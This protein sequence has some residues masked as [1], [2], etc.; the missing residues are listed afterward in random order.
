MRCPFCGHE[1]TS[2]KDSRSADDNSAIRRRRVCLE[3][4]GRFTTVEHVQLLPLNVRKKSGDIERF[5]R[6]KLEA[7]L[8]TALHKRFVDEGRLEKIVNGIIRRL[9]VMGSTEIESSLI[10][11]IVME[12]LK[13]LDSVAYVRFASVYRNFHEANDFKQLIHELDEKDLQENPSQSSKEK[14]G[15]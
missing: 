2:V 5:K 8:Q 10:G 14:E 1:T 13:D 15:K 6:E 3:C 11:E 7:S 4:Q 9:E 12:T